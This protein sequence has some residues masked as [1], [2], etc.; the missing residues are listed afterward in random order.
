VPQLHGIHSERSALIAA[1]SPQQCQS[2][3]TFHTVTTV[4]PFVAGHMILSGIIVGTRYDRLS[5]HETSPSAYAHGLYRL[6]HIKVNT[7]IEI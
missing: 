1:F 2:L 3:M 4:A 6:L 7:T 5:G